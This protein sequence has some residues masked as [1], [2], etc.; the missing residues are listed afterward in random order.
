VL[1]AVQGYGVPGIKRAVQQ[2]IPLQQQ[3]QQQPSSQQPAKKKMKKSLEPSLLN[4]KNEDFP[5]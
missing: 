4:E 2:P 5:L 1:Q 3:P